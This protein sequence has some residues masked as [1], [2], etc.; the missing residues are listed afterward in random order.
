M[1]RELN[2]DINKDYFF[3]YSHQLSKFLQ[4]KGIGYITIAKDAYTDKLFS[5]YPKS[6]DLKVALDEYREQQVK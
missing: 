4:Y 1:K 3:C 2:K 5:L 6:K